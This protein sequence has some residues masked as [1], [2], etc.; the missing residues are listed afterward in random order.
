MIRL[1]RL[2]LVILALGAP[3]LVAAQGADDLK[4]LRQE[5]ESLKAGIGAVQRDLQDIKALLQG[6]GAGGPPP[7][8]VPESLELSVGNGFSKGGDGAPL[9]LV[10]FSDFQCP[11]CGRHVKQTMPQIERDYVATGKLRYV[12]RNLPLEQIHPDALRAAE[13]AECAG[14][15]GKYWEMHERLFGHQQALAAPDLVRYAQ[16]AGAEPAAFQRCL[17]AAPHQAKIRQDLADAQAAG[18][19]GTPTFFLGFADGT[20]KVKVARRI[21]GAQPY[22]VFK[23]AIDAL[24]AEGPRK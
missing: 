13:A 16:E 5:V 17:E 12:V 22:P 4:A 14:D 8:V 2:T 9:V 3:G 6:R 1:A 18:I 10:E 15:Q 21:S 20:D 11:F 23:G 19:T 7:P 24:L